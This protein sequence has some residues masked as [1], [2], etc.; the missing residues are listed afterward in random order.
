MGLS[1]ISKSTVSKLC[2]DIDD[3]VGEFLNR[4]LTG[5]WPY[6]WLDATYLKVHT[7]VAAAI[8]QAFSQPDREQAG[9]D[10]APC[11][12]SG[13][14]TL[15]EAR[16]A[17][18]RERARRPRGH[19]FPGPAPHQVAQHQ[20]DRAPEQR[21]EAP[22]PTSWGSS[23]TR[24]RS[25]VS[26][27]PSCSSRTTNGRPSTATCRSR[28]SRKSM[29]PSPIPFSAFPR[30][31]PDHDLRPSRNSHHL[32]GRDH[33]C[34]PCRR[35]VRPLASK[36]R[37][38]IRSPRPIRLTAPQKPVDGDLA[39]SSVKP[40]QTNSSVTATLRGPEAV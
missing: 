24:P 21:G 11:G 2:K 5:D 40:S 36:S 26:S 23:R 16:R 20:P 38:C 3:R 7:V 37:P 15:A 31:P 34:A 32:D 28:H 29:T 33:S 10:L 6:F 13:A 22:A 18:G 19:G 30:K 4:P 25:R 35:P 1:G 17:D 27:V 39:R 8:R 12:G 14:H 9:A